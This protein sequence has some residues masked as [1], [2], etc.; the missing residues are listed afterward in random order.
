VNGAGDI[1]FLDEYAGSN[2][3]DLPDWSR[4]R[5]ERIEAKQ[6]ANTL[7]IEQIIRRLA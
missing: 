7:A 4:V 1:A 2:P 6:A 3:S 5:E